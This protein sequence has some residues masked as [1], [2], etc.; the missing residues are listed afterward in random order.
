[1]W[2]YSG[3]PSSSSKDQVRF[4]I[5]DTDFGKQQ[6]TDEEINWA[7]SAEANTSSAAARLALALALKFGRL[8]DKQV[9]DLKISYSA[10]HKQYTD[11]ANA[12]NVDAATAGVAPYCGGISIADKD[13][14]E[15][16]TDRV[17]PSFKRGLHDNPNE[18]PEEDRD[19]CYRR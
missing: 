3:D 4:L 9:G 2:S 12:L 8:V 10:L 15:D 11:L 13:S 17:Q 14:V 6:L 1:M 5:G 18:A 16:E 7:I 19:E